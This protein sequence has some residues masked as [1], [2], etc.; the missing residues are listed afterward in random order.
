MSDTAEIALKATT[1]KNHQ[2]DIRLSDLMAVLGRHKKLVLGT[3]AALGT[4]ALVVSLVMAPIFASV[5]TIMPPQS[6]SP[7]TTALLG[8]LGSLATIAGGV[9]SLKNPNDLYVG[10]LQSRT[11]ADR[12][13]E[14][15]QLKEKYATPT[16]DETRKSLRDAVTI[17]SE[18]NGLIV[19]QAEDADP[20]FAAN[21]ANAFVEELAATTKSLTITEASQRRLFF[22]SQLES[23]NQQ[24]IQAEIELRKTQE[25]TGVVQLDGQVQGMLASIGQAQ[26]EIAAKEV[27]INALK[28][29]ATA[30]HPDVI[31]AQ[32]EL[33]ALRRQLGV[34]QKQSQASEGSAHI[35]I[36]QIPKVGAE[37]VRKLREVKYAETLFDML[38]KQFELAKIDEAKDVSFIQQ[39]DKAVPAERNSKPRRVVLTLAGALLGLMLGVLMAF[40]A[41]HRNTLAKGIPPPA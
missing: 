17:T 20:A 4:L 3:S 8:Q 41:E 14:R 33:R 13:I 6:Q 27:Q 30:S 1:R 2:D 31:R 18:K 11:I 12:L 37:Y 24:L 16:L 22:Q 39:L 5:A 9:A 38:A 40:W 19:I 15:F 10:I 28:T 35:P 29:Y 7:S 36:Q 23:A 32:E 26:G 25:T 34:L 21:L